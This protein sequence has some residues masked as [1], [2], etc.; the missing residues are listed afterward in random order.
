MHFSLYMALYAHA[1]SFDPEDGGRIT[2]RN[3]GN[4]ADFHMSQKPEN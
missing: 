2:F 1:T 4:A 3:V